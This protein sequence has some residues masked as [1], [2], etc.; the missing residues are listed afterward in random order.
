MTITQYF[1]A[2]YAPA[3]LVDENLHPIKRLLLCYLILLKRLSALPTAGDGKQSP[4]SDSFCTPF[5]KP[6]LHIGPRLKSTQHKLVR[7]QQSYQKVI[8][9]P[10]LALQLEG[11]FIFPHHSI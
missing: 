4:I 11:F 1:V 2:F 3:V 6:N 5:S 7:D 9:V 8:F 10:F